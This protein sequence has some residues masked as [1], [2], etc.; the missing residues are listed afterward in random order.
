M[1]L[2]SERTEASFLPNS[3]YLLC[4]QLSQVPRSPD[5]AI[6]VSM[7]TTMTTRPITLPLAHACR[8]IIIIMF[9]MYGM[10]RPLKVSRVECCDTPP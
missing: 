7:T 2:D 8:V 3:T 1:P 6:F 4:L 5:L 10:G 9:I